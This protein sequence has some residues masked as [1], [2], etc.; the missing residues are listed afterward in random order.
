V[1]RSEIESRIR[2]KLSYNTGLSASYITDAIQD[3]QRQLEEMSELPWFL[4]SEI[5]SI[6]AV[7]GEE[8]IPVPSDFLREN[9]ESAFFYYNASA[10]PAWVPLSKH[11]LPEL[12]QAYGTADANAPEAYALQGK[13][14]RIFPTPDAAY[15]LKLVYY[16]RQAALTGDNDSNDWSVEAPWLLIGTAG[17][18]VAENN[19]DAAAVKIFS[20]IAIREAA[21]LL[22]RSEA[23]EHAG[24]V[25]QR[26]GDD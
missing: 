18:S 8:R 4:E 12:R 23:R 14:F 25:Y 21:R 11:S 15:T 26:G 9:V 17:L 5:S 19:R 20:D 22:V 16:Q 7:I 1:I 3:A 13:Y 10:S 6:S 24:Q 2:E